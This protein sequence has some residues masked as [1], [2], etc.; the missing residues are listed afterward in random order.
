MT[1][2][3]DAVIFSSFLGGG[4][5]DAAF[6]LAL[7]PLTGFIYV[8][9][10]TVSTDFPGSKAGVLFGTNQG[11]VDGY[12]TFISP[13]GSRQIATSYFGTSGDDIIYGIQ[14]DKYGFPFVGSHW[15]P[16][17]SIAS[18]KG[19]GKKIIN[20]FKSFTN[21]LNHKVNEGHLALYKI[22]GDK[23]QLIHTWK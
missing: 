6:V 17:L 13:D 21:N 19:S 4:D 9:G 22:T 2:N 1:P 10:A 18:V 8:A 3:L 12:V 16:H 5:D 23:H 15:I 20:E 11:K 14:F 7:N